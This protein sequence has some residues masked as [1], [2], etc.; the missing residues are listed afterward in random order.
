MTCKNRFLILIELKLNNNNNNNNN[1]S[2]NNNNNNNNNN[3]NVFPEIRKYWVD[4][5]REIISSHGEK[6]PL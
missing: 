4:V 2:N 5:Q 3:K 1:N 6:D